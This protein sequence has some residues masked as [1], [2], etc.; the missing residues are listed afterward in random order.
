[1]GLS[2]HSCFPVVVVLPISLHLCSK[3][4]VNSSTLEVDHS[5]NARPQPRTLHLQEIRPHVE[6]CLITLVDYELEFVISV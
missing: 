2:A 1:M 3:V 6:V 4:R 5:T